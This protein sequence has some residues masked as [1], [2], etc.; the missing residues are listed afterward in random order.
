[1]CWG[2]GGVKVGGLLLIARIE[3]IRL[4]GYCIV[5]SLESKEAR[6]RQIKVKQKRLWKI[7]MYVYTVIEVIY[8]KNENCL[9][10]QREQ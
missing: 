5:R 10:K 4:V 8:K 7:K 3:N 9:A 1:M 6:E 2:E